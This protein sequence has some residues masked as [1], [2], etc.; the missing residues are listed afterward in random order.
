MKKKHR[1][2][3]LVVMGLAI[4]FT[5]S[6]YA[7]PFEFKNGEF[8]AGPVYSLDGEYAAKAYYRAYGGAAGG[9][10]IWVEVAPEAEPGETKTVYY[11]PGNSHFSMEWLDERNLRIVNNTLGS[12]ESDRTVELQVGE[13]IYDESGAACDSLLLKRAY[14]TCYERETYS[15]DPE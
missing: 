12:P 7:Y 6:K 8:Y 10:D 13:E 2:L 9:V 3:L 1:W 5:Y 11:A 14:R 15:F 4:W